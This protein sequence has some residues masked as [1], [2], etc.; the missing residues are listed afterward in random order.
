M[1][2]PKVMGIM[3]P[4]IQLLQHNVH[5]PINLCIYI[6]HVVDLEILKRVSIHLIKLCWA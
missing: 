3:H 1:C 5:M 2:P 6:A 4:I